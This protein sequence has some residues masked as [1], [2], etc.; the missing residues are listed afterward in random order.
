MKL[1]TNIDLNTFDASDGA[2]DTKQVIL[3]ANKE[4]DF[5]ALINKWYPDGLIETELNNIL[6]F[7]SDWIF[8]TLRIEKKEEKEE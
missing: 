4:K 5:D 8:R 6:R 7:E 3:D 2:K 1:I